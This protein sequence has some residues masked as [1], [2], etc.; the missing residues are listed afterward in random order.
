MTHLDPT[1]DKAAIINALARW[2][3]QRPGLE[4]ENYGDPVS[5]RAEARA[6]GKDLQDARTLLRYVDAS[7]ITGDQLAD[8]F[9]AFSGRLSWDGAKLSYCTGQYWPTE[10][11]KA[12]CA[13]LASA[14][15]YYWRDSMTG[16]NAGGHISKT[17]RNTFGRGIASRWFR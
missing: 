4:Y 15:R 1:A 11:R 10:Y 8:A 16:P 17:A 9:R 13:V 3:A 5:Y 2:I 14:I 7:Q 12:A 6:I